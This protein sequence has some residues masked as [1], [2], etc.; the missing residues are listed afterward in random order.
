MSTAAATFDD[1]IFLLLLL[2]NSA[3]CLNAPARFIDTLD[4]EGRSRRIRRIPRIALVDP[5][6]SPWVKVYTSG[7][8]TA[9]IT[10]TGLDYPTF[11]FL[12]VEFEV[13]YN[14]YTP[15]SRNG[16][17]ILKRQVGRFR[18]PRSLDSRG[19]LALVL[20]YTRTKGATF[21]LCM[22]FGII[23]TTASLFLRFGRRLLL[24]ILKSL[25]GAK[26]Q[27][28]PLGDIDEYKCVVVGMYPSL[29]DVWYVVDGL[30]LLLEQP[31]NGRIQSCFYNG[32]THDH[33]VTNIFA[34][35]PNGQIIA[36]SINNPG[37][38]HDSQVAEQGGVYEKLED[39][40]RITG[41][42][43][44][45]DSAF[46]RGRYPFLI[47]SCQTLPTDATQRIVLVNDEATSLRQSSEWGMRGLQGSFPRLKDRFMYE[48]YGERLLV[49][50]TIVHLYNFR[51]RYVGMNQ[52]RSV[53]MPTL[54]QYSADI[55]LEWVQN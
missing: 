54:E 30:K 22:L 32:W 15:Y 40:H 52:I 35:A 45:V 17:I 29:V 1:D 34:F 21:V 9:M 31:R 7:S 6:L 18:R 48:E 50:L 38:V 42:K 19:C 20:A 28:P 39:Q 41:G 4:E 14:M 5:N 8:E 44:V 36:C 43:G 2:S 47:K 55:I 25:D 53:F 13:L 12:A 51:A 26:V 3:Q 24:K 11:N 27:M 10:F 33:Y 49:L 16:K 37:N 46:S 23:G